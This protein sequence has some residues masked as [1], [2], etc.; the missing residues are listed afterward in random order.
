MKSPHHNNGE[1]LRREEAEAFELIP[2]HWEA[3]DSFY[4]Y[5]SDEAEDEYQI[6]LMEGR[7][8]PRRWRRLTPLPPKLTPADFALL[9]A[10]AKLAVRQAFAELNL[11]FAPSSQAMERTT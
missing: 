9:A 4:E 2:P 11:E 6:A 1:D 10:L 5:E 7:A 3:V 8:E